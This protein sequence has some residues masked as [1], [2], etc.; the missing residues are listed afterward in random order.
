[1]SLYVDVGIVLLCIVALWMGATWLVGAATRIAR[2]TGLSELTIGLT[3]VALGTSA[4]ELAVTIDSALNGQ[5][6]ISV[7]NVVG[8]NIFNLGFILGGVAL[9]RAVATSRPLVYRDGAALFAASLIL[10]F[11]LRDLTLGRWESIGMVCLLVAYVGYLFLNGEEMGDDIPEGEFKLWDIGLLVA[12]IA[13]VI[14]GG[15]FLVESASAIARVAGL[16][17]WVIGVTIVAAGTS[18]PELATSFAAVVRG[19]HGLSVGNLI[20]SDIFNILGV[21]G[22]AGAI[23]PLRVDPNAIE[24]VLM[25]CLMIGLVLIL[26]RSRWVLSRAEGA[27]LLFVAIVRWALDFSR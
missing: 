14:G 11:F 16:S 4:P 23:Q 21:L 8:S 26:M 3:I 27:L 20:G 15:H 17:E 7:G 19:Q 1:M 18:A 6:D 22:V 13:L 5:A 10:L 2:R 25:V 9:F 24:S 12:G